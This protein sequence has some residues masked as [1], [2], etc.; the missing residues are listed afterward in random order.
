[1][2]LMMQATW[3][4]IISIIPP[5]PPKKRLVFKTARA[6][7]AHFGAF[8]APPKCFKNHS[9]PLGFASKSHVSFG[10]VLEGGPGGF[11]GETEVQ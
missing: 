3:A 10:V 4:S 8:N 5:R 2:M 6:H 7:D 11:L 1:M 9:V